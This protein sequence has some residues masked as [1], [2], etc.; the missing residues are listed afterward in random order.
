M[1]RFAPAQ[2][3][4]EFG[5]WADMSDFEVAAD[6][7]FQ[8]AQYIERTE[9][10]MQAAKRIA[11][12]D[13]SKRFETE[14]DPEGNKWQDLNIRY[15]DWKE[16][17]HPGLP[18]LTLFRKG[19]SEALR[20]KATKDSAFSVSH[21]S[22]FFSTSDLPIYWRK[23]QFGHSGSTV[24]YFDKKHK[25][26]SFTVGE[27]PARPFIGLSVEAEEKI[28]EI[29]DLWLG[30]GSEEAQKKYA[31]SSH[32]ILQH[33]IR[34]RFGPKVFGAESSV[35]VQSPPSSAPPVTTADL[36]DLFGL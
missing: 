20:T 8:L 2:S 21:D 30:A 32:G 24:S 19:R 23:H 6:V 17:K 26:Q 27:V 34:G 25:E 35:D 12:E 11:Q 16:K 33:R 36:E 14:T 29:F 1:V 28:T 5:S 7:L 13:M 10:P 3:V 15:A 9:V 18:I 31:I 4:G 22:V